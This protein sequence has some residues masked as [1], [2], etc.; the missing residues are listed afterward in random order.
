[1]FPE[2]ILAWLGVFAVAAISAC[3]LM[4]PTQ[5]Q[6]PEGA[7]KRHT[8][9]DSS[10]GAD[11][12]RLADFDRDGRLDVVSSWEQGG[13]VRVYRNPG[14][15]ALHDAWPAVTVGEV[16]D[17]EDAFFVDLDEDGALDVVSSCEGST[18]S[19]FVHWAPKDPSR[20]MDSDEWTTQ[21]LP[22]AS[23]SA[24]WMFAFAMQVDGRN[25]VDLVAGAKREGSQLGWFESPADPRS[26]GDRQWHPLYDARWLMTIRPRDLDADG[27]SDILATDRH[28]ERRGAF[29][30]ENPG[31]D[32]AAL[33]EW[34][35]HR[36]GP[37][38]E[39]EAMYNTVADLDGDGLDDVLVAV[40]D[41]PVRYHRRTQLEP[42]LW[43]THLI[44]MPLTRGLKW[45][46]NGGQ[47]RLRQMRQR[48]N[49]VRWCRIHHRQGGQ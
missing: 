33:G 46:R 13:K 4:E 44:E 32:A 35:E 42:A 34:A 9:D 41:G 27:G 3:G 22:A 48:S 30:L 36:I 19:I 5:T 11:G 21:E 31:P 24:K 10:K 12:V 49:C 17:P 23:G 8:I 40:K 25:S 28:G 18:R 43:E 38:G 20:L 39:H 7:W 26:L 1:M 37:M 14:G 16:G 47:L 15:N 29:W 45:L 6:W 2:S